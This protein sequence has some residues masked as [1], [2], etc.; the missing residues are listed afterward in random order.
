[1]KYSIEAR[2]TI[3]NGIKFRS[4]LEAK[5]ACFFDLVGWDWQYEPSEINGYNPDFIIKT[6]SKAYETNFI[7]V[8]IKP[9]IYLTN[10]EMESILN[11]YK[12]IDAHILM[13]SDMPFWINNNLLVI[14]YGSQFL[15]NENNANNHKNYYEIQMKSVDD[16]GSMLMLFDG[17][18]YDNTDRKK[19]IEAYD[20]DY[21]KV[22]GL[23]IDAGNMTK[24][25]V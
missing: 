4:R 18:I 19:F 9:S 22:M 3:Y 17:M 25:K 8:E 7:I 13:L 20:N 6:K 14:G 15:G 16:F 1:M 10:K 24:F 5:W 12:N 2:E 21:H 11:K 23:W